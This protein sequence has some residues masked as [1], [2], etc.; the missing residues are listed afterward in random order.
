MTPFN[1]PAWL[2][3]LALVGCS[4]GGD[5]TPSTFDVAD[6]PPAP[7]T[8]TQPIP[9]PTPQPQPGPIIEPPIEPPTTVR[10]SL[11]PW[12]SYCDG[13]R[14]QNIPPVVATYCPPGLA[15]CLPAR[16]TAVR[17]EVDGLPLS[18]MTIVWRGTDGQFSVRTGFAS[19]FGQALIVSQASS[20]VV[21][22]DLSASLS[23]YQT[24]IVWSGTTTI[25][26]VS[27]TIET[28]GLW[29]IA[30]RHPSYPIDQNSLHQRMQT[31]MDAERAL[32]GLAGPAATY[33]L[34]LPTEM[35][36][37]VGEGNWSYGGGLVTVNYGNPD[38]VAA[39]GGMAQA[40]LPRFAHEYAHELYREFWEHYE[41]NDAA[42]NEGWA[43]AL[44]FVAGA[45]P[46]DEFGPIGV[47]GQNF[48]EGCIGIT[49][50]HDQGNCIFWSLY[51]EGLLTP[52]MLRNFAHPTKTYVTADWGN[53]GST[54]TGETLIQV[55]AD[56]TGDRSRVIQAYYRMAR[57]NPR[58]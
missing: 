6:P 8:P 28:P 30:Y 56:A 10:T 45:L 9:T 3:V 11:P 2:C 31:I 42:L 18:G 4:G 29:S 57:Q 51:R 58:R 35:V 50:I 32:T 14:C 48:D 25:P 33:A 55:F 24:P 17:L 39:V 22:S 34:L 49:E 13:V 12:L 43:D 20:V 53:L 1:V 46:L 7:F 15:D 52:T 47:R 38:F 26:L 21:Q 27:R 36:A 44:A 5:S 54:Q 23:F 41:G 37:G 19:T 40:V 16:S